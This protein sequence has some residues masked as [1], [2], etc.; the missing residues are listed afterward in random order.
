[1]AALGVAGA[2][3][4]WYV[5]DTTAARVGGPHSADSGGF[6]GRGCQCIT[7]SADNALEGGY[8]SKPDTAGGWQ[9]KAE[10]AAGWA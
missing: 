3:A 4:L 9:C 2:M 6:R 7:P 8:L 1:M 10:T 5:V